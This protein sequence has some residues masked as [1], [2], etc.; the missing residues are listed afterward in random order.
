MAA[1]MTDETLEAV[2]KDIEARERHE[3]SPRAF[4]R[5]PDPRRLEGRITQKVAGVAYITAY[6]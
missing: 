5:S 2:A 6:I 1:G 4:V 3:M